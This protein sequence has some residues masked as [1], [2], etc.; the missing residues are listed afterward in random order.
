[1]LPDWCLNSSFHLNN[2]PFLTIEEANVGAQ[3]EIS[4][5]KV[6]ETGDQT[7]LE[8]QIDNEV[9]QKVLPVDGTDSNKGNH[10]ILDS[11]SLQVIVIYDLKEDV[12]AQM[13][14]HTKWDCSE[15][16]IEKF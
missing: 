7:I 15:A 3:D 11:W 9:K 1:M 14:E 13:P 5:E 8:K 10:C 6:T 12:W 4:V 2:V 16:I